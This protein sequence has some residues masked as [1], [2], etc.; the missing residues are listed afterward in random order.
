VSTIMGIDLSLTATGVALIEDREAVATGRVQ[1]KGKKTDTIWQRQARLAAIADDVMRYA[2]KWHPEL[3]VIE[4]PSY[5]SV[6]GAQHDRSGLWWLV[7]QALAE[8]D[9]PF[10]IV[11]PQARAKYGT[12][13]GNAAK[14]IVLAAVLER[15]EGEDLFIPDDNVA[16]A[17]LLASMGSRLLGEPLF[18]ERDIA[19]KC[20]EAMTS[21]ELPLIEIGVAA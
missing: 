7:V 14:A 2:I 19:A 13:K 21:V 6:H 5:G 8:L 4:A 16:D 1:T 3:V 20:L 15:F 10:T 12:G 11:A 17:L 18:V 9:F